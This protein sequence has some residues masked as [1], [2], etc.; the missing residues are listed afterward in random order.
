MLRRSDR[1][2]FFIVIIDTSILIFI[3]LHSRLV[4]LLFSA[5]ARDR[6][7]MH[8]LAS[9]L[10]GLMKLPP[11]PPVVSVQAQRLIDQGV[12]GTRGAEPPV[13]GGVAQGEL[14]RAPLAAALEK[15]VLSAKPGRADRG[16]G[17]ASEI[18]VLSMPNAQTEMKE[19]PWR[20]HGRRGDLPRRPRP[21]AS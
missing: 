6:T 4:E 14:P 8:S 13:A 18:L 1:H 21:K 2:H 9:S 19:E 3:M 12:G 17:S 11:I 15:V 20:E 10:A 16:A 7:A 5:R